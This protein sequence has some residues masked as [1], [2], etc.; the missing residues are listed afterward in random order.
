MEKPFH[1]WTRNELRTKERVY[2]IADEYGDEIR[3]EIFRRAAL[4]NE[5]YLLAS[6][7]VA[8]ISALGSLLSRL[9]SRFIDSVNTCRLSAIGAHRRR[10]DLIGNSP[11]QRLRAPRRASTLN[12]VN[13]GRRPKPTPLHY[14]AGYGV[15]VSPVVGASVLGCGVQVHALVTRDPFLP[16]G[17]GY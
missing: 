15:F 1:E 13:K 7:V 12:A 11:A 2:P 17:R 6:V 16:L 8:A 14:H 9:Y 10:P 5:R 3:A 4:R